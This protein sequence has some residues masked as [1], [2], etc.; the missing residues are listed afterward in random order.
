MLSV[1]ATSWS[2]QWLAW[3]AWSAS[4][5]FRALLDEWAWIQGN[6][7]HVEIGGFLQQVQPLVPTRLQK[8]NTINI[9]LVLASLFEHFSL[10]TRV[11]L[12]GL[13]DTR[14]LP[15]NEQVVHKFADLLPLKHHKEKQHAHQM[16]IITKTGKSCLL[17]T[18]TQKV[19]STINIVVANLVR[20]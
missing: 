11:Q 20:Q 3:L 1:L 12:W 8:I 4:P 14:F 16:R 7:N 2:K 15:E 9:S 6:D 17:K 10:Q 13:G 19:I 5:L 18:Q